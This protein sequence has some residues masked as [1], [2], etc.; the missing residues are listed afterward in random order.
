[1]A[2]KNLGFLYDSYA[3]ATAASTVYVEIPVDASLIASIQCSWFDA[4]SNAAITLETSNWPDVGAKKA[5][6]DST[7][8]DE[9]FNESTVS[10]TGPTAA[11]RGCSVTHLGNMASSRARL[12]IVFAANTKLRIAINTRG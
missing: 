4:T 2:R 5:S 3:T 6:S 9:W 8:A 10:I 1:M 12:K 11:A 7:N